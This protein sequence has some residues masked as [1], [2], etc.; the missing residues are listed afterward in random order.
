MKKLKPIFF[1][2]LFTL[3]FESYSQISVTGYTNYVVGINTNKNKPI[4]FDA[5][6]FAY[7]YV[8]DL[9]MEFNVLQF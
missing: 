6:I 9:P 5:K 3:C 1:I 8:E 2:I 4:S 7:H